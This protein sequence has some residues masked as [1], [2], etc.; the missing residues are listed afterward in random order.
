MNA[1]G[2]LVMICWIPIVLYL[3]SRF[4]VQRALI[5]SFLSAWL[6]LPEAKIPLTGIPDLTKM[7]ATCYGIFIA[8]ALFDAQRFKQIRLH[9]IDL[10]ML[11]WCL[12]PILSSLS[13]GLGIYDGI[14]AALDQ[15]VTWGFPY[16]LGRLY[17]GSL[18][19]LQQLAFGILLGGLVYVPL[20]LFELR[21]SPQLHQW[22]YGFNPQAFDQAIRYGGFRPI[23][24][25]QHGLMVGMWLM[26]ATLLAFW[27]WQD[28]LLQPLLD[29]ILNPQVTRNPKNAK[30]ITPTIPRGGGV[31]LGAMVLLAITFVLEKSTGAYFLLVLGV[32]LILITRWLKTSVLIFLV[33]SIISGYLVFASV[34]G[35]TPSF[36]AQVTSTLTQMTN[37]E[38]ASSLTFR[39]ENESKLSAKAQ[40]QPWFGWGGWGRARI[41]DDVGND[42]SVTDSLWI[43]T[44][45]NLGTVGL[46][47]LMSALLLPVICFVVF[48]CPPATWQHPQVISAAVLAIALMMYVID[49]LSNAMVN[50]IYTLVAGGLAGIVAYSKS[51]TAKPNRSGRS[52]FPPKTAKFPPTR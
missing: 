47:S 26:T 7:S 8:T 32:L 25:M 19:G 24:F 2:Y 1:F 40:L 41:Y 35:L 37:A 18:K 43:I 27:F 28:G 31:A 20:C 38:R 39:L 21:M 52:P 12:C 48:R 22:I 36:I 51:S 34:G 42:V 3:F 46:V 23:V 4:P 10:P 30:P 13:N 11:I 15:T 16:W 49:C 50:P 6:F 9:W 33:A 44:F 29:Q 5:I 14:S 45:G 17:L